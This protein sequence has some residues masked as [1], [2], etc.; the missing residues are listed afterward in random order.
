[1]EIRLKVDRASQ[2]WLDASPRILE[3]AVDKAMPKIALFAE[4]KAKQDFTKSRSERGGLHVRTGNLRRSIIGEAFGDTVSLGS[5]VVYSAIH[6]MG[7]AIHRGTSMIYI[8]R[9][10]F[11][12]PAFTENIDK[13]GDILLKILFEEWE[14]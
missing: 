5:N 9:R 3:R 11:L 2:R 1:M 12:E 10:P 7:G 14:R 13:I 6:E 4:S 8:P